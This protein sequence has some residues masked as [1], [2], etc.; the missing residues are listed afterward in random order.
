M[1][2]AKHAPKNA[3]QLA[4]APYNPRTISDTKLA[5]LKQAMA[6]FGDLSGIVYNRRTGHLVGGH[7]RLKTIPPDAPVVV[8]ERLKKPTAQ[9]T[10]A[11]GHI[12]LAGE[13]WTYRE[14]DWD[15]Q[16]EGAANV[17]ANKHGGDWDMS[18][19]SSLLSELDGNGFDMSLTGFD[20][21]E[22]ARLLGAD[23]IADP[24]DGGG[25]LGDVEF[26]VVVTCA[27]E[28]DQGKLCAELESRGSHAGC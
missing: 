26:Q 15:E 4:P 11:L 6:A 1:T 12:E 7:Q 24:S 5:M 3:A 8:T 22:L 18:L 13:R 25:S 28:H 19:L 2:T 16:T 20:E 21:E 23:P 10:V 17:A 9:G 14:V 27:N